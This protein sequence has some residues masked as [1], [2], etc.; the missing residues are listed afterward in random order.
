[1]LQHV[2]AH[3]VEALGSEAGASLK[4]GEGDPSQLAGL[5]ALADRLADTDLEI[6]AATPDDRAEMYRSL[7]AVAKG[8]PVT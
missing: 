1:M 5:K 6:D 3:G 8:E 7:A 2:W 4:H